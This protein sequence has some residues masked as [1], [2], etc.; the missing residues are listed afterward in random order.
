MKA[1]ESELEPSRAN[2]DAKNRI[3]G[4]VMSLLLIVTVIVLQAFSPIIRQ[5]LF[6]E[7]KIKDPK[8]VC[9]ETL[10][11]NVA[12]SLCEK[13]V[14][15]ITIALSLPLTDSAVRRVSVI[16]TVHKPSPNDSLD[17]HSD[18]LP[19]PPVQIIAQRLGNDQ[20]YIT[21]HCLAYHTIHNTNLYL[22]N[23]D[24]R[25]A[26]AP[27]RLSRVC[28]RRSRHKEPTGAQHEPS[29]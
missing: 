23:L 12:K 1:N 18:D 3:E 24:H 20:C 6:N 19:I 2:L 8:Q 11:L 17:S 25:L 28:Q 15:L 21:L 5:Q 10:A 4:R 14:W 29:I 9:V 26:T 7:R 22:C 16:H 27:D 13:P